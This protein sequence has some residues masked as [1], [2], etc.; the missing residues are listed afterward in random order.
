MNRPVAITLAGLFATGIAFTAFGQTVRPKPVIL[1]PTNGFITVVT[2]GFP[3]WD[4]NRDGI[5][6]SNE[7]DAAVFNPAITNR[8]AAALAALKQ[9]SRDPK[10]PLPVLTLSNI[11]AITAQRQPDL[12]LLY[13]GDLRRILGAT[14]RVL[15]A[16]GPPRLDSIHQGRLGNCFCLAP[17]G[18]LLHRDSPAV[19]AMFSGETNG[20]Y[21][22]RF[23]RRTVIVDSPTDGEI[24]MS[25]SN[26]HEGI[27]VNL[28]EKAAGTIYNEM[29]PPERQADSALDALAHGGSA[30]KMLGALTGHPFARITFKFAKDAALPPAT[31]TNRLED[32]RHRLTAAVREHRLMTC[33]TVTVTTP[34]LT[35]HHAYAVLDYDPATDAVELWNPHGQNFTP[36]TG[37][38]GITTGYP[39]QK[40]VFKLPLTDFV[41]QFIGM[42][43]EQAA[44]PT[45]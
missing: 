39:T 34:G 13:R 24:A 7:L 14:N 16:A 8:A 31:V 27:W 22:V 43:F 9:A 11:C 12:A 25:S 26:E 45:T 37:P 38:P 40:G 15:F 44:P 29:L 35:P 18:A 28:Y 20:Q 21:Q 10:V 30:G 36:P 23:G 1:A 17:L 42:A 6:S 32:L 19:M 4:L 5:L 2:R 41:N 3:Q 33:G